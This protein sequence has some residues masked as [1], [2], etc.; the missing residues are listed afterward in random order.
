LRYK[1]D[2]YASAGLKS[3]A[4]RAFLIDFVDTHKT[5]YN[6]ETSPRGSIG[7]SLSGRFAG[8][9]HFSFLI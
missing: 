2:D 5:P 4:L 7:L 1:A 8:I 3:V 6:D 9:S